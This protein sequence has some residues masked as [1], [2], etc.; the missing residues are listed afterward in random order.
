M[1]ELSKFKN[2]QLGQIPEDWN[3]NRL[4]EVSTITRLAGYEYT[5]YWDPDPNGTIIALR[6]FNISGNKL[7]L[8]NVE[9]ISE[10]LSLKLKRSKLYKG[11][12]VFPCVGSIGNAV[13]IEE[14]NKYH[15]NQNIAKLTA[16]STIFPLFLTHIL[17]SDISK[18][19]I[20]KFNASTSQPN[21]L[22]GNLRKFYVPVPPF[23]E[24]QKIASILSNVDELIQKTDKIIKQTQSL[25]K[26]L[27][28]RLLTKGI[29]HT[30]FKKSELGEVPQDWIVKRLSDIGSIVGGGT[31]DTT[32]KDYWENGNIAWAVP[33]DLTG[34]NTN[35]IDKTER[36]ITEKG[37]NNSA[38]KLLPVGAVLITSRATI[39]ECAITK[40]PI[41]TN[42]GFQTIVCNNE[43]NNHFIFYT[44][45]FNK[46]K[47]VRKSHGTT[48]LEISK[49]NIKSLKL[50]IPPLK[51]QLKISSILSNV[52]E[53]IQ[54]Q[55]RDKYTLEN[56]KKGLME[57]LLT[58]K[59]RVKV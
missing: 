3:I 4:E 16:N 26:G 23:K 52:D 57:Q 47:L 58:G 29:G 18:H 46:A 34:L 13:L 35:Y 10:E 53:L 32:K 9:R 15:I 43:N 6:G 1:Q 14:N 7:D 21:V 8:R 33:T 5:E 19:Q 2:T 36:Y 24:Q 42:Q 37:L 30:K 45:K 44:I 31:P 41:T 38:A 25:K 22:V 27:M 28:Q 48:F 59:I 17:L 11:D 54:K 50:S 49:T 51:E 39:G 20:I 12:I 40:I 56:L 55:E